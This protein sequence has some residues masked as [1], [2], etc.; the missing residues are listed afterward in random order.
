[1]RTHVSGRIP[2]D[3]LVFTL[4]RYNTMPTDPASASTVTDAS[5]L[6]VVTITTAQ[7]LAKLQSVKLVD[8]AKKWFFIIVS[9]QHVMVSHPLY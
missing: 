9:V 7:R 1:M 3:V 5:V 4:H 8:S 6:E 2:H